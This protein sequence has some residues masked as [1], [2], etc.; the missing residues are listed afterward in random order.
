MVTVWTLHRQDGKH[1]WWRSPD[2]QFIVQ[3]IWELEEES[4]VAEHTT[5]VAR[6]IAGWQPL[7]PAAQA[8]PEQDT[9]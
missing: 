5:Q 7:L 3:S 4:G 8:Q 6:P 2:V 9:G 1:C